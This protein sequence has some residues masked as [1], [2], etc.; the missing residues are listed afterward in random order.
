MLLGARVAGLDWI[1]ASGRVLLAGFGLLAIWLDPLQPARYQDFTYTLLWAYLAYAGLIL[2]L[3]TIRT[4]PSNGVGQFTHCIDLGF[5]ALLLCLTESSSSPFFV[6]FTF[7]LLGAALRWN[8]H[9]VLWTTGASLMVLLLQSWWLRYGL[10]DPDF[11]LNRFIIRAVYLAVASLLLASLAAH[12]ARTRA[13]LA[14]LSMEPPTLESD[15]GWPIEAALAYASSALQC[16]RVLLAWAEPEEPWQHLSL[17]EGGTIQHRAEAPDRYDSLIDPAL[18]DTAFCSLD[19]GD[20]NAVVVHRG[21]GDFYRWRGLPL[22]ADLRRELKI[23]AL[24]SAPVHSGH[25]EA[26]L[27]LLEPR[28]YN[29]ED[30]PLLELAA[31]RIATLIDQFALLRRLQHT[32]TDKARLQLARDI[33]DGVLQFLAGAGLSLRATASLVATDPAAAGRRLAEL[34]QTLVNEQT[35]LRALV[36]ALRFKHPI[37]PAASAAL[38]PSLQPLFVHLRDQWGISIDASIRPEN[39]ALDPDRVQDVAR[40]ISEA[41]ANACRHGQAS[42]VDIRI[43]L[44]PAQIDLA[45]ADN[46]RGFP[47]PGHYQHHQLQS[48]GI[49]PRSLSERVA[50]YGGLMSLVTSESGTRIDIRLP[51]T[52]NPSRVQIEPLLEPS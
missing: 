7:S 16:D 1:I 51:L 24:M 28:G 48:L 13:L 9:G 20:D 11:E 44:M 46:G 4:L 2:L 17:R 8:W 36:N 21:D 34:Q 43:E 22:H 42:A 25:L 39:A 29:A 30:L 5:F 23:G 49:G 18:G 19:T 27:F 40:L 45:I 10:E 47:L 52:S 6:Y 35:Q 26:R 14:R 12:Q 32:A 50:T 31:S 38:E 37:N 15:S 41:V 33:H 3:T